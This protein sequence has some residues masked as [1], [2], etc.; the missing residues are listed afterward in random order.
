[1]RS[2]QYNSSRK[3][4]TRAGKHLECNTK[5]STFVFPFPWS[6]KTTNSFLY[7]NKL[8]L[9]FSFRLNSYQPHE[10]QKKILVAW[11]L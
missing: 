3:S 9:T 2:G 7:I 4:V 10:V 5:N 11:N 6:Y 8:K 1:M